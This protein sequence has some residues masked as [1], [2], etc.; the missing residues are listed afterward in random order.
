MP[1]SMFGRVRFGSSI[2]LTDGGLRQLCKDL[3]VAVVC[4]K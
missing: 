4:A 1:A 2:V 3:C